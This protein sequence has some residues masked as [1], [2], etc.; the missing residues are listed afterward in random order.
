[1]TGVH[2]NEVAS[3]MGKMCGKVYVILFVPR[4]EIFKVVEHF[5]KVLQMDNGDKMAMACRCEV[6]SKAKSKKWKHTTI[7]N[8]SISQYAKPLIKDETSNSI[9]I[10]M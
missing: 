2:H 9:G 3:L 10:Y 5:V 4:H 8:Q 6:L 1:M 7:E